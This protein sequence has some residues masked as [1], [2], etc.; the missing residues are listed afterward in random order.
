MK[1]RLLMSIKLGRNLGARSVQKFP[2][3]YNGMGH[4]NWVASNH[5][6]LSLPGWDYPAKYYFDVEHRLLSQALSSYA[7]RVGGACICGYY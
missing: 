6:L 5:C 7:S 2:Q 3:L 4:I 1:V